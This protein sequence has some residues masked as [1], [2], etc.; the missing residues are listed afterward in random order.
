MLHAVAELPEHGIRNVERVLRDEIHADAFRADQ[1]HDLLDFLQQRRRRVA[2]QQVGLV[3]EEDQLGFGQVARLR[4]LLEKLGQQPEQEAAVKAWRVDQ[5]VGRQHVDHAAAILGLHQVLDVEHGLAEKAVATL[6][7][8]RQQAALDGADRSRRDVAVFGLELG[9]VLADLL[10]HG[11]QVLQVQQQQALVVG[12]L[13]HQLQH[14]AL[15]VVEVQQAPEQKRPHVG[16]RRAHRMACCAEDI[17]EHHR[18]GLGLPILDAEAVQ[19]LLQFF[20]CGAGSTQ[21]RQVALGVG[22]EHRHAGL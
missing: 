7:F 15:G 21:P 17:P 20:G 18:G 4:Q 9:G 22:K 8:Q 6:L 1:A 14:T 3:E 12:D 19:P 10:H 16:N 13:K 5:L 11:P 2:E